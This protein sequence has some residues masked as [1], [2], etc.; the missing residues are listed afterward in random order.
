MNALVQKKAQV[1]QVQVSEDDQYLTFSLAG[2]MFGVGIMSIK[3]I[4]EY[5]SITSVP[6]MPGFVRG[7]IN[8]RGRV[9]PVIDLQAR[10]G[11]P[12]SPVEKRTCIVI[13]EVAGVEDALDIGVV[14]DAVSEVM[15]IPASDI[16][17][18]PSFGAK[19]RQDFLRGMGKVD[20]KFVILLDI[21]QVLSVEELSGL[22]GH[23]D[24]VQAAD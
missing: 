13:V 24:E 10:F 16:E 17:K 19:L 12:S 1:E 18:A 8:L 9:V 3:E 4:I 20:G 15:A 22:V 7:V 5:G 21:S 2:E 23:L 11:R 6:L 14:V